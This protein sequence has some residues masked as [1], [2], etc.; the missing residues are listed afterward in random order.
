MKEPLLETKK[1]G[2]PKKYDQATDRVN[3]FR[4]RKHSDG[5]R[6]DTFVNSQ[7]SWRITSLAKAWNCSRG[8]AIERLIL[9]ADL[10]HQNI[11]LPETNS[12]WESGT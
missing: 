6:I 2:R 10:K 8:A 12:V 7:G 11:L 3:D 5:K 1:K 4:K 9:E